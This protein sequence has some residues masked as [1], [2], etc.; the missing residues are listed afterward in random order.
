MRR[1]RLRKPANLYA[2]LTIGFAQDS[3]VGS[4]VG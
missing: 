3:Q 2:G 1:E 4:N